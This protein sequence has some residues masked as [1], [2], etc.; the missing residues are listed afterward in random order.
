MGAKVQ[1]SQRSNQSLP[2]AY[3]DSYGIHHPFTEDL[4]ARTFRQTRVIAPRVEA[5]RV[6]CVVWRWLG[7]VRRS[8]SDAVA[9][10]H[11]RGRACRGCPR[12]S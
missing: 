12:R 4:P 8:V 3:T 6:R 11:S 2:V 10:R 9:A 7:V 1:G 5:A